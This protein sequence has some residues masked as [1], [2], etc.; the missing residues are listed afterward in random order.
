MEN[1]AQEVGYPHPLT[2]RRYYLGGSDIGTILGVNPYK[3]PLDLYREKIGDVLPMPDNRHTKR[4][5]KLEDLAAREYMEKSGDRLIRYGG[6][7]LVHPEYPFLRAHI[8][9]RILQRDA[10]AEIKCPSLGSFAKIKREGLRADYIAQMHW[11]LGMGGF[12]KGVWVIF[13]ADQWELLDFPV[14][15]STGLYDSFVEKAVIFWNEY[16]L[17]RVPPPADA[18]DESLAKELTA[19]GGTV[20]RRTDA[21]FIAAMD[22]LREAKQLTAEAE[23]VE[24]AAKERVRE[25]L[26]EE[27]RG[28]FEG[29]GS[30][31][32][33]REQAGR[34]TFDKAALAGA[35]PLDRLSVGAV[36]IDGIRPYVPADVLASVYSELQRCT[37]DLKQFEKQG[38]PF[39]TT[40]AYFF[41]GD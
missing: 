37:L 15:P 40:R 24:E 38:K 33:V 34:V 1:M 6:S 2:D 23:L 22:L 31:L 9:R 17:K 19:S 28:C 8:D 27:T 25:V 36:V 16:V 18:S 12:A 7:G 20:T 3:T 13:C 10:I 21:D 30:R 29:P 32:Y 5:V 41:G 39:T 26:G 35:K 4:G 14:E 11:Y